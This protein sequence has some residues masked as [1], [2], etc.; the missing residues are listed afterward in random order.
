MELA[1]KAVAIDDS[2]AQAHQ[3]LGYIYI[4]CN[5]DHEKGIAEAERAVALDP[6]SAEAYT[7]LG[8]HLFWGGPPRRSYPHIQEGHAPQ[9]HTSRPFGNEFG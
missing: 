6:N 2:L 5:R 3:N 7:Q 9:P 8:I 4:I 1:Q